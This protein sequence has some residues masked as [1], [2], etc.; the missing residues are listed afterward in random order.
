MS[1]YGWLKVRSDGR[2]ERSPSIRPS[3]VLFI[4]QYKV[5][6]TPHEHAAVWTRVA[7]VLQYR[8][9]FFKLSSRNKEST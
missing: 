6:N 3:E 4:V 1:P 7:R 5:Q 2:A 8:N 9:C